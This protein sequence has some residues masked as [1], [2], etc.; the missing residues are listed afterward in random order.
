MVA[1]SDIP[2]PA[3][4]RAGCCCCCCRVPSMSAW[5]QGQTGRPV[6]L[7]G[8]TWWLHPRSSCMSCAGPQMGSAPSD[9]I[10][11]QA[12]QFIW[13]LWCQGKSRL[14]SFLCRSFHGTPGNKHVAFSRG[15]LHTALGFVQHRRLDVVGLGLLPGRGDT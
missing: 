15:N 3:P 11:A 9:G 4:C 5:V 14:W 10:T 8:R 6:L 2:A 7:A 1:V 13:N 12:Q